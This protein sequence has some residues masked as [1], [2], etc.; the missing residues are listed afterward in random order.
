MFSGRSSCRRTSLWLAAIAMALSGMSGGPVAAQDWPQQRPITIIQP[1]GA[2][3]G[4]DIQ[5]RLV[6]PELEQALNAKLVIDSRPGANGAIGSGIVA[7]APPDGYT[8]LLTANSTYSINPHV[9]K[10]LPYDQ[11]KDFVP[12]G[13]IATGQYFLAVNTKSGFNSVADVV[14]AAK[15][16]PNKL[17]YGFWAS[18]VLVSNEMFRSTAGIEIR[19]VPYKG[20][21][22]AVADLAAGRVSLIFI[23]INSARSFIEAGHLRFLAVTLP[24]RTSLL[25]D[26]PTM[27]EEGY[28]VVTGATTVLFAPA[29]TPRP[30]LE[31]MNAAMVKVVQTSKV[32]RDKLAAGALEPT[33]MGLAEVDAFVR[34][35]MTRWGEMV[36]TAGLQKE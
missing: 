18:N 17:T 19:K 2:G 36:K 28:P 22:E 34:S 10:E 4:T 1:F 33:S 20:S 31:R 30:I 5:A 7:R 25:P 11:L 21:A 6:Q 24:K 9:M 35:E 15:A 3:G 32:V 26:I 13:T 14:K 29:G 23:D 16:E 27:T 8:F 12:V